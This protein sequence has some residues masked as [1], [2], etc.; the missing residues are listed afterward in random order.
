MYYLHKLKV[1]KFFVQLL[2][3]YNVYILV[4]GVIQLLKYLRLLFWKS[5]KIAN[6]SLHEQF[7]LIIFFYNFFSWKLSNSTQIYK[8]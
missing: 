2:E 1:N 3:V 6:F 4:C 5:N 8:L 7:F